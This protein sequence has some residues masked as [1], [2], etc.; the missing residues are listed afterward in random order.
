MKRKTERER[1][2]AWAKPKLRRYH[3]ADCW[4]V[5]PSGKYLVC[6]EVRHHFE[7]WQAAKLDERRKQK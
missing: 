3:F 5:S 6:H 7:A 4:K 2:E 1:F